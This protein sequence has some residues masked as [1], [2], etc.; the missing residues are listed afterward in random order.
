MMKALRITV[1][2]VCISLVAF[3]SADAQVGA[4][5]DALIQQG[6]AQLQTGNAGDALATGQQ[7]IKLDANRWEAYALVGCALMNLKRYEE[8]EDQLSLAIQ[9]APE[10]KLPRIRD[11]RKQC[12]LAEAGAAAPVPAPPTTSQPTAA[13]AAPNPTQAEIVLWKSIENSRSQ[14]DFEGYLKQYPR[15]T[16]STL[17]QERLDQLQTE[18]KR[19]QE[20]QAAEAQRVW[21]AGVSYCDANG[22]MDTAS[23]TAFSF[24]GTN[25]ASCS[26]FEWQGFSNII[27]GIRIKSTGKNIKLMPLEKSG[28]ETGQHMGDAFAAALSKYCGPQSNLAEHRAH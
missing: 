14:S 12:A 3:T 17:A 9:H 10:S 21:A 27:V 8:A 4:G 1:S 26:D 25:V 5:Y 28:H 13:Q 19:R 18:D 2:V 24:R 22:G 20:Q 11:L 7:A 16:F 6:K 15:G 23:P